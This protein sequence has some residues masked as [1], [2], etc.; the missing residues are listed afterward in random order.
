M[1]CFAVMLSLFSEINEDRMLNYR[2]SPEMSCNG[3]KTSIIFELC[4]I[5]RYRIF[6]KLGEVCL[7]LCSSFLF[8]TNTEQTEENRFSKIIS[9]FLGLRTPKGTVAAKPSSKNLENRKLKYVYV[10]LLHIHIFC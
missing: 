10:C 3:L 8:P 6:C 9:G 1:D 4:L 7:S 5:T 2:H